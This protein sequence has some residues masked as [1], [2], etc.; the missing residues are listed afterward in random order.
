MTWLNPA[1]YA[2]HDLATHVAARVTRR[3]PAGRRPKYSSPG[4]QRT[5]AV[6]IYLT[7]KH[8][9]LYTCRTHTCHVSIGLAAYISRTRE[10]F[11]AYYDLEIN[12]L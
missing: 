8:R 3:M 4:A 7:D 11:R 6:E 2:G 1:S 12:S 5:K 10:A 9:I